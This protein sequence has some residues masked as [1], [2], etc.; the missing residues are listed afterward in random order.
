MTVQAPEHTT[1]GL[2]VESMRVQY[3]DVV[4][5]ED[6]SLQV[7]PGEIVAL[8]G[9][10]GAGKS[11]LLDAISGM[12]PATSG[13]VSV[14]GRSLD[15]VAAE[16]RALAI[17]HVPEGRRLF[18]EH[19]VRENLMLAGYTLTRAERTERIAHAERVLP[20]LETL[21]RRRGGLLSG[22]EQQMVALG[23][24]IMAPGRVLVVDELSLG[25][26]PLVA[27]S[28]AD[29]LRV[30]RDEGY[31]ILLVE[32]Y[33]TLAMQVADRVV[34]LDHGKVVLE[35][36]PDEVRSEVEALERAYLGDES[37]AAA[38]AADSVA[39]R[40]GGHRPVRVVVPGALPAGRGHRDQSPH[41]RDG[42]LSV[43]RRPSRSPVRRTRS[44]DGTSP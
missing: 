33:I 12:V 40:R 31:A 21:R 1:E 6:V 13:S 35:G 44:S 25:L 38:D 20:R 41:D 29:T 11:S 30:L 36:T 5:V 14:D 2:V 28:F 32:Q 23:R 43:V 8:L 39:R 19:T 17:G 18:P 22:G 42:I 10:N 9:A 27:R 7:R 34:V 16:D 3:G 26:A 15:K 37:A 4:A 24:G